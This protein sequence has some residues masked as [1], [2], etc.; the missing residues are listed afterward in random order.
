LR[1]KLYPVLYGTSTANIWL[2]EPHNQ[3]LLGEI[4]AAFFAG[5]SLIPRNISI[6][7][8]EIDS[9]IISVGAFRNFTYRFMVALWVAKMTKVMF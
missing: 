4:H 1:N 6:K 8:S 7:L 2:I 5:K 9:V 3:A